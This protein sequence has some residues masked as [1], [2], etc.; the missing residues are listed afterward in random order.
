[1]GDKNMIQLPQRA[2]VA[3]GEACFRCFAAVL[4]TWI[5]FYLFASFSTDGWYLTSDWWLRSLRVLTF[6]SA[7]ALVLMSPLSWVPF[8]GCSRRVIVAGMILIPFTASTS[9]EVFGRAQELTLL[10][11][12]GEKPSQKVYVNRWW[13]FTHHAIAGDPKSGWHGWD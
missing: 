13:P 5:G 8:V 4:I 6:G 10:H 1:M 9:A 7:F 2:R 11:Q 3:F 12:Y